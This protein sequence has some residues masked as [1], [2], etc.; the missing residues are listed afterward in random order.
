MATCS[1][2]GL[3]A[4]ANSN[5]FN[6]ISHEMAG[7]VALQFVSQ[8]TGNTLTVGELI[9]QACDNEFACVGPTMGFSI[10]LQQV[11]NQFGIE[12][13]VPVECTNLI[14]EG[15]VYQA[16]G[17][18]YLRKDINGINPDILQLGQ[19]YVLTFGANENSANNESDGIIILPANTPYTFTYPGSGGDLGFYLHTGI[20]AGLPVTA[21]LCA[22]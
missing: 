17:R 15:S 10:L 3:L 22:L 13:V 2:A 12:P 11:C 14:P 1:L 8:I 19:T 5:G 9:S 20:V 21:T 16:N 7:A 6:G 4:D 18:F